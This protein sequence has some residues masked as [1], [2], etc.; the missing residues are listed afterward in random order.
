MRLLWMGGG[1]AA[2]PLTYLDILLMKMAPGGVYSG[3]EDGRCNTHFLR[4]KI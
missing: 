4:N 3:D 1:W 2:S